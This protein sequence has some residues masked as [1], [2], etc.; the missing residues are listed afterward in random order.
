MVDLSFQ[1]GTFKLAISRNYWK[2]NSSKNIH[3]IEQWSKDLNDIKG[4]Y[5]YDRFNKSK[6]RARISISKKINS[7]EENPW[8]Q[9]EKSD[10]IGRL[11]EEFSKINDM[12]SKIPW[13]KE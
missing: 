3:Y 12:I 11:V 8:Y 4:T 9:M 2:D 13:E 10:F 1:N 7:E 5:D 6:S